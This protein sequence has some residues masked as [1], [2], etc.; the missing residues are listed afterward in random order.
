MFVAHSPLNAFRHDL[1][2]QRNSWPLVHP[3]SFSLLALLHTPFNVFETL[4]PSEDHNQD[5]GH[6]SYHGKPHRALPGAPVCDGS[7]FWN[8]A[9]NLSDKIQCMVCWHFAK[10]RWGY[11][12]HRWSAIVNRLFFFLFSFLSIF[13]KSAY[14][15]F[16]LNFSSL[17]RVSC[18][19]HM[20]LFD[21]CRS[22]IP[23]VMKTYKVS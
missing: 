12:V 15:L 16:T 23:C 21:A 20:Y 18:D 5:N 11:K 2:F 17:N 7:R 6:E 1:W 3:Q 10:P 8:S 9:V 13:H 14:A 19:L 22:L 4:V